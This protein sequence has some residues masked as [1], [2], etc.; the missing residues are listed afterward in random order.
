MDWQAGEQSEPMQ[1][2]PPLP[3][4][5]VTENLDGRLLGDGTGGSGE[6][7]R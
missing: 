6:V 3:M 2:L 5:A 4:D 7:G 1:R